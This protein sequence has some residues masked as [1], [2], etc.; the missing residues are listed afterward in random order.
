MKDK[1]WHG[2]FVCFLGDAPV[3]ICQILLLTNVLYKLNKY[4]MLFLQM[5][6]IVTAL[7]F[8][9]VLI[10]HLDA[11]TVTLTLFNKTLHY[12]RC[13]IIW[14]HN[15]KRVA[16]HSG[17]CIWLI[18]DG[19]LSG[20]GSY[21]IKGYKLVSLSKKLHPHCSVLVGSRNRFVWDLH[22]QSCFVSHNWTEIK[23]V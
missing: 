15:F 3:V 9:C 19:C 20:M 1:S 22:Q 23:Y 7:I 8:V 21:P 18:F 12:Q 2:S 4:K 11:S 6:W 16:W 5:G 10:D 13:F 14:Y 17:S